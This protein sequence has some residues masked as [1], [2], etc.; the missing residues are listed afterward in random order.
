M[1]KSKVILPKSLV[2]DV[3][4][5]RRAIT[6]AL[7]ATARGIKADFGVT[8]QTWDDRPTFTISSPSPFERETST[9]HA[10]YAMLNEGTKAHEIRPKAGKV[11]RFSSV[12]R[13]K[14][15]PGQIVSLRGARGGDAVFSRG[16]HHP[17]TEAREWDKVIAEKWDK[18]LPEIFQRA[19]D[20]EVT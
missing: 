19:V 7:T 20:S 11:L 13:P 16:V 6:N 4:A 15:I 5:Q 12:F 17:G 18:Q 2:I 10:V 8:T 9:D 3:A 1:A 14:T